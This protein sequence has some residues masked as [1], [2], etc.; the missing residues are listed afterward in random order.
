MLLWNWK[1]S[2]HTHKRTAME[3]ILN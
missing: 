3:H 2:Y 1:I